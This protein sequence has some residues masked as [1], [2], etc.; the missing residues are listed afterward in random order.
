M[1]PST[2]QIRFETHSDIASV[3]RLSTVAFGRSAEADLVDALRAQRQVVISLVA[4]VGNDVIGSIVLTPVTLM[5]SVPGLRMLGLGPVAVLP[6]FQRQGI[7]SAL[8]RQ[9]IGQGC[10]DGWHA[11][12]VLGHP[13]YC[14]RFGFI[15]ARQF[16]LGCEFDAPEGAFMILELRPRTLDGLHGVVRYQPEFFPCPKDI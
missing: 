12:V 6:I 13:E 2:A 1:K 8:I 14:T 11:I 5:P 10:A 9:A 16:G 15:P 7:G 4:A 3:R